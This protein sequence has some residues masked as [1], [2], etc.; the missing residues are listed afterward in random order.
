MKFFL[1][2][3]CQVN[4]KERMTDVCEQREGQEREKTSLLLTLLL[5]FRIDN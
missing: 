5:T 1:T 2:R 4:A 3:E